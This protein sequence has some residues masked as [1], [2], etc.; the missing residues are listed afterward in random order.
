MI[1]RAIANLI[2]ACAERIRNRQDERLLAAVTAWQTSQRELLADLMEQSG[3]GKDFASRRLDLEAKA[4]ELNER[5]V[6]MQERRLRYDLETREA[7]AMQKAYAQIRK[8][9]V[10][11]AAGQPDAANQIMQAIN[12]SA[13]PR[14]QILTAEQ[15]ESL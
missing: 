6:D 11:A 7:A 15:I 13:S 10:Q 8:R 14:P 5:R 4:Q 12:G 3:L 9:A 2:D 1:R